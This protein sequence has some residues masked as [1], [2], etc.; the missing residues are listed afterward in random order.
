MALEGWFH[1]HDLDP[2][3][4]S[5][6]FMPF[7]RGV[8]QCPGADYTRAFMATFLHVLVSKY[9]WTKIKGGNIARNP[10]LGFGRR[11]IHMNF[12]EK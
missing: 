1:I 9:R 6:N 4:I 10:N 7:G 3:V 2:D 8:R 12:S 11:G 5:N